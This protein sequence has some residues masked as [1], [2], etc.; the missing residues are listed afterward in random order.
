MYTKI[1]DYI[2]RN[3]K[4]YIWARYIK[5]RNDSN[6]V[7]LLRGYYDKSLY[8]NTYTMLINQFGE[9]EP[10]KLIVGILFEKHDSGFCSLLHN[11]LH[12]LNCAEMLGAIPSVMWSNKISY[13]DKDM[14][15]ITK[16][17]FEYYFISVSEIKYENLCNYAHVTFLSRPEIFCNT[18]ESIEHTKWFYNKQYF[19]RYA[20]LYNKYI[21]LNDITNK[22]ITEQITLLF[23]EA[24]HV[25]GVHVRG[26]DYA[27]GYKDH[28]IIVPSCEH[29]EKTKKLLETDDVSVVE[30]FS[31]VFQNKVVFFFDTFRT[32]NNIPPFMTFDSRPLHNYK[33]GLEIL[34]DIYSLAYCD[35]LICGLSGVPYIAR[36]VKHSV[37]KEYEDVI[38]LDHG[39]CYEDSKEAKKRMKKEIKALKKHV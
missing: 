1:K 11:T 26:T 38:F 39:Y 13:Y 25:I 31:K 23:G 36:L 17:V 28:P 32:A 24:K 8:C 10:N 21:H 4:L 18:L 27:V 29:I 19:A 12:H 37:G 22:Y 15:S 7:K 35:A 20:Y 3:D 9:K 30:L 6:F 14:D 33:L 34:R 16:N 2:K 5:S